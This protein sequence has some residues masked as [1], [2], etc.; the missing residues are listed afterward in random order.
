[1]DIGFTPDPHTARGQFADL[2]PA[3]PAFTRVFAKPGAG[4][5]FRRDVLE[6][7][8]AGCLPWYS[9]KD[10]VSIADVVQF[11]KKIPARADGR[12][13]RWTYFHEAAPGNDTEREEY[14]TYWRALDAASTLE[15]PHIELVQIQS[16]YAMR[17]RMD[18]DW[19]DWILPMV[20]IGFDCYPLVGY[21]YEPPASMFGLLAYAA[22]AYR[23]PSWGVPE[24]GAEPRGGQRR[25][26]WL[27]ECHDYLKMA[28]ASFCG[29]WASQQDRDGLHYDYRL[30]SGEIDAVKL[31]LKENPLAPR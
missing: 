12:R 31:M 23:C 19:Q 28:G 2:L 27:V 18:T 9:H 14:L 26:P 29:I 25:G 15:A 3:A 17:W 24:L 22:A 16:N 10:P 8:P 30:H 13:T 11:W 21:R 5:N 20:S 7:L 1:M 6:T 4:L